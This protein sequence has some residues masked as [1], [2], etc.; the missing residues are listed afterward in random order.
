MRSFIFG[1]GTLATLVL[2]SLVGAGC[3]SGGGARIDGAQDDAGTAEPVDAATPSA[4]AIANASD[5]SPSGDG[6]AQDAS[7]DAVTDASGLAPVESRAIQALT[8]A[9]V[10]AP[11]D[12]GPYG[13]IASYD[14]YELVNPAWA[15]SATPMPVQIFVPKGGAST[16]PV[17]FFSHP[18][19]GNDYRRML[20]LIE[21]MVSHDDIVVFTPYA[22]L[23]T[24]VC[25]RYDTLWGGFQTAID[26]LGAH[27]GADTTR[28]GFFGH[29]FG[30]G[31]TPWI[32]HQA[33]KVR[34][35]GSAGS[36][37]FASAPWY[38]YRM[39]A[40]DWNDFPAGSR[41]TAMVYADDPVN[42]HRMAIDEVWGPFPRS[43][44]YVR[45]VSANHGACKLVADHGSPQCAAQYDT[46]DALDSWGVWRHF[47]AIEACTLRGDAT[48]C[49]I[50]DGTSAATTA[51]GT[52]TSDGT[53]VPPAER[54]SSPTPSKASSAYT[55]PI[56]KESQYPCSGAKGG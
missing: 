30:G 26:V 52:W 21:A 11:T 4:D 3:S 50:A 37:L 28:V 17:I 1:L 47:A 29:S 9:C 12:Y 10:N 40:A 56:D 46:F 38:V 51:M 19:G 32:A 35:W 24:S 13:A 25:G 54:P 23:Q 33:I 5:T 31:A 44:G 22:T 53:A 42:D 14:R 8:T 27:V 48:A 15:G 7:P 49:T 20:G 43:K 2:S 16:H 41:L 18:Y 34:G 45:L 55:F 39:A 36:F 6:A